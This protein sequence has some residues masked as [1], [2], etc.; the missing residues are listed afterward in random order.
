MSKSSSNF[1][2]F[3]HENIEVEIHPPPTMQSKK[4]NKTS[5]HPLMKNHKFTKKLQKSVAAIRLMRKTIKKMKG[6]F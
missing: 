6:N 4:I 1:K 2:R 5:I 3:S